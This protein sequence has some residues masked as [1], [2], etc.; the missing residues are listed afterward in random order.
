MTSKIRIKMG[1]IEIEYEGSE[2]FLKEELPELLAAVSNLYKVSGLSEMTATTEPPG[3]VSCVTPQFQAT[4]GSIAAKLHSKTGSNL[5]MAAAARLTFVSGKDTFTRKELHNEMK[6][7][8]AYYKS[9]YRGGN[10][11]GYLN[12]LIKDGTLLEPSKDTYAL[13]ASMKSELGAKLADIY[14]TK[15]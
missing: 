12:R 4:T 6:T 15:I 3:E 10:L 5:I 8:T 13:S 2:T 11:S 7:A 9:T 14:T 1:P